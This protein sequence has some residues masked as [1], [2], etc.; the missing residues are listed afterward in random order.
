[1]IARAPL[2]RTGQPHELEGAVLLLA[3]PAGDYMTGSVITVDGG[4]SIPHI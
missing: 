3:S 4:L 2:R 1:M